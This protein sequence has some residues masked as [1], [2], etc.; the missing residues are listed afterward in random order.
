MVIFMVYLPAWSHRRCSSLPLKMVGVPTSIF[1]REPHLKLVQLSHLVVATMD[2]NEI[3]HV[4]HHHRNHVA[5]QHLVEELFVKGV[6][7]VV[8]GRQ[9]LFHLLVPGG[10]CICQAVYIATYSIETMLP[11]VGAGNQPVWGRQ[12]VQG[13]LTLLFSLKECRGGVAA[14]CSPSHCGVE[15]L[16]VM[17]SH[18]HC[19]Q[20]MFCQP[21]WSCTVSAQH[22]EIRV[23]MTQRHH[24]A[25][26][27]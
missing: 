14:P 15:E 27:A 12:K 4:D 16:S 17:P 22:R 1:A 5:I 3:V 21:P 6:S 20:A 25:F 23:Q 7:L 9:S 2:T 13:L 11:S 24:A 8:K 19:I 26:R 10:G 18:Y